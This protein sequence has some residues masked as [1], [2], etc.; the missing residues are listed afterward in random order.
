MIQEGKT[1]IPYGEERMVGRAIV[2]V[3]QEELGAVLQGKHLQDMYSNYSLSRKVI[4]YSKRNIR[5]F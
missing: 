5:S 1:D 2:F 4:F 3:A